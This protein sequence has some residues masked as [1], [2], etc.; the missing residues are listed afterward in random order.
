MSALRDT[1]ERL[2]A[3]QDLARASGRSAGRAD[4]RVDGARDGGALLAALRAKGVTADEVRGFASAMRRLRGGLDRRRRG[5]RHRRHRGR[6]VRQP[7]R[8]DRLG[9]LVASLGAPVVKHGNRSVSSRSGS[10]D[11]LECLG[12]PVPL[13]EHAAAECLDATGFTFLFAPHYHPP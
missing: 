5:D 7:E 4:G 10:A 13:D 3:K 9:L 6:C 2:L 11:L 12:L 1:L 8:F